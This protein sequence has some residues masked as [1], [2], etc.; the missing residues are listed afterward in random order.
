MDYSIIVVDDD[1]DFLES[2]QR[3]LVISGFTNIS[4]HQ[5][6]FE[7]ANLVKSGKTFDI[8]LI[9]ITMPGMS[10]IELMESIKT[11][12]PHIECIVL[13]AV[14]DVRVAVSCLKKG[15]YDYLVK[16]ISRDDL[17]VSI[18]RAVEKKRLTDI[19]NI[20]KSPTIPELTHPEAFAPIITGNLSV[21][22]ILKEAELHAR[23]RMPILITGGSGTGKE[24]LA[25]AIHMASSREK[26]RFV[27]INMA[28]IT[29][30]LFDAEFFG[31]TKGAFTG[32]DIER[33]GYLEYADGGTLFL[34]EV[35][36]LP[37]ELQGKLLRFLQEGEF[38]R[39]GSNKIQ[40]VDVRIIAATNI[41]LENQVEK[42]LFRND[43]YF[44]LK[45]GWLHLPDLKDRKED[46]P[47]LVNRFIDEFCDI[48]EQKIQADCTIEDEALSYLMNYD[49]PGNIRELKSIVHATLNLT[50][51][52]R[53]S[54]EFLP[55]NI[56]RS[57]KVASVR[58]ESVSDS[59]V[60]LELAE[61]DYILKVYHKMD[62][63]KSKTAEIL[64]IDRNTLRR[65]I[66]S[67]G[68]E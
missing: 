32:A 67:Y 49:Y 3:G 51:G 1:P 46:I 22:R 66:Q 56:L 11:H 61:K 18:N 15:A 41:D 10:G 21:Q 34:D 40:K 29:P 52:R 45:G 48:S 30:S 8:A 33:E 7:V 25:R 2:I 6:P 27:P 57:K 42:N 4:V 17:A 54:T 58:Q 28:A 53:I 44:R 16:P 39:L 60:P 62:K 35:G 59:L 50:Q 20:G 5:D 47:L 37:L 14:D 65:K 12:R 19:V 26:F 9:D 36:M 23:S 24:L 43:L 31:H 63:N 64:G 13:T 68:V 38:I 55:K